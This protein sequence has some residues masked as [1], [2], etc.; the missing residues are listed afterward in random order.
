M[1]FPCSFIFLV[2]LVKYFHYKVY[3]S[4]IQGKYEFCST[5]PTNLMVL[6]CTIYF[7]NSHVYLKLDNVTEIAAQISRTWGNSS[8]EDV[9]TSLPIPYKSPNKWFYPT[10]PKVVLGLH[11][12]SG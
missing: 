10:V 11:R 8:W 1:C 2:I 9:N 5:S 12:D 7:E 4:L 3:S 6:A